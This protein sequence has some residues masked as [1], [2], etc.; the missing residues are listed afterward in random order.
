MLH[1]YI[2]NTGDLLDEGYVSSDEEFL[3]YKVSFSIVHHLSV[4]VS[5]PLMY[6]GE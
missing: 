5:L 3:Q 1:A 2:L 6:V 4:Q